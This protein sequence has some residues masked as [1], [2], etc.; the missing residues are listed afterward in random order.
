[1]LGQ[2]QFVCRQACNDSTALNDVTYPGLSK[3]RH[4]ECLRYGPLLVAY[5]IERRVFLSLI[6]GEGR[7]TVGTD[8]QYFGSFCPELWVCHAEPACLDV[9]AR[10]ECLGEKIK[11]E[12]IFA[13]DIGGHPP[14]I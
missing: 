5:K 6:S 3:S 10:R 14:V 1:M 9:S 7:R 2:A 8:S 11:N 12:M 13:P 4:T